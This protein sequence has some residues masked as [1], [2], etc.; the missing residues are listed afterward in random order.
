MN[1]VKPSL[2]WP[3]A[4]RLLARWLDERERI[5]GLMDNLPSTLDAVE[6]ARCQHLVFGVI[7]H[8][9]RLESEI[10]R[11]VVHPPRFL[12]R[13]ILC[14]LGYELL[15]A[16]ATP[17]AWEGQ[18][19]KIVHHAVEQ[20]KHIAS[21]AESR[22]VNAVGR[23]LA[24]VLGAQKPPGKLATADVLAEY[25]SHPDWLVKRWLAAFGAEATRQLLEWNQQP[26]SVYARWRP[27]S[28]PEGEA[29][30][31]SWLKPTDW[32]EFFQLEGRHWPEVEAEIAAG[33]LYVQDPATRLAVDELDPQ[34]GETWLDACAAP[35]GKSLLIADRAGTG[36][37]VAVD[38]IGA[39]PDEQKR[40]GRFRGNLKLV[41]GVTA[42]AL[43]LDVLGDL[44]GALR[45]RQLP[46]TFAGVLL[47]APCSN[48]GV[49]RHRVDVKWRLQEGDMGRHAQQQLAL[50][51]AVARAV[52]PGGRLV[53]STCSIDP[54]EN[55]DVV[56][57]FLK[58][59]A[60][61]RLEHQVLARPWE[62]GHDGAGVFKLVRG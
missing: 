54:A 16:A 3:E 10:G 11:L 52:A 5:D 18:V 36:R 61:F 41:Q 32:N 28:R 58:S 14:V 43:E 26:A 9:G 8:A 60:R 15:E 46:E 53:Y 35:G 62:V 50:L 40:F 30:P 51:T 37:L 56:A 45:F 24:G 4:I 25:Y 27:R 48:T 1:L 21:P 12:T 49:M 20:T 39:G 55:E 38:R 23:K 2:A 33:R 59:D 57:Q 7:R 13:A 47:D 31:P 17:E 42:T 19:A 6:R 34:P 22:L 44:P 29:L